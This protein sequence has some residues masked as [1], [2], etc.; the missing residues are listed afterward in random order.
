MINK[1]LKFIGKQTN[2]STQQSWWLLEHITQKSQAQ[3]LIAEKLN[4]TEIQT[5]QHAILQLTIEQKPLSYIIGFVPFLDLKIQVQTPIL[6]PRPETEEWVNK[7]IIDFAPYKDQIKTICDIGTGSGCI[8]LALAKHF[9]Q[10]QITAIDINPKALRLAQQNAQ[11]NNIQNITFI[12]SDLFEQFLQNKKFDV[13]VSNPP[14]IDPK[15]LPSMN[16]QVTA[17]EDHQALFAKNN[18]TAI[19]TQILQESSKFLQKNTA[20]PAQLILEIDHDQH[21]KVIKTAQDFGWSAQAIQDSFGIWR[22]MWCK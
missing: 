4:D 3:L 11:I 20:L 9:P 2:L 8:A 12:Q 22:T 7:I 13:I 21:E 1:Y 15:H 10:A 5:I 14:Y 18:G 19:I 17:W 6:I 16:K